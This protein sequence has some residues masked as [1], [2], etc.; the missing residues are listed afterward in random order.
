MSQQIDKVREEIAIALNTFTAEGF[1]EEI[2]FA[3]ED[4]GESA[5]AEFYSA[6][7]N[8]ISKYKITFNIEEAE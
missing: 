2:G 7:G 3:A 4:T 6:D 8:P 1:T 5:I